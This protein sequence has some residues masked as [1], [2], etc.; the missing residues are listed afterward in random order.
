MFVADVTNSQLERFKMNACTYCGI[1]TDIT[2]DHVIPV[3]WKGFGRSYSPGDT[4]PACRECNSVLSD[5]AIF[6]IPDRASYLIS[7][8]RLKYKKLIL[9]PSWTEEELGEL[10]FELSS[11]IKSMMQEQSIINDRLRN[12]IFVSDGNYEK[13]DVR[14]KD[15]FFV[16]AYKFLTV[17]IGTSGT[18][19]NR[20]SESAKTTGLSFDIAESI[21][22]EICDP[23]PVNQF[24]HDH[25]IPFETK[26]I[27]VRL[28]EGR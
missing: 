14:C 1:T 10:S 9:N 22:K 12:L 18:K 25:R 7:R 6:N 27:D 5:N 23:N 4:I 19:K 3:S 20:V 16:D 15:S 24:K 8:Y 11:Q 2:R 21:A 28:K 13:L 17:L 26:V